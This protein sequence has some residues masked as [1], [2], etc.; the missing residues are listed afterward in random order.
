MDMLIA[1]LGLSLAIGLLVGLERGW[2]ERSEPEGSRTAGIRTFGV[3]GLLGGVLAALSDASGSAAIFIAGFLGFA[4]I[5]GWFKFAEAQHDGSFSVTG[6][7]AAL[8]VFAL[9]GLAVSGDY[10]AAAA[11]GAALAAVLASRDALHGMLRR[12]SWIE[13]RSAIVLAVMT[14]IILP[15][16]PNRT[17]DPWGGFNPWQIWFFTVLTA[18]ISFA[19]YIATRLLGSARG[20]LVSGL[21]GAIVSSTAVTV[22]FARSATASEHRRAYAGAA[23]LAAM[24]SIGRVI[25]IVAIVSPLVLG[26]MVLPALAAAIAFGLAGGLMLFR[27]GAHDTAS[28]PTNPFELTTLLLFAIAFAVVATASAALSSRFG[29]TGLVATSALSGTFDVDVAVLSAL[30]LAAQNIGLETIG[31]AVLAALGANAVGRLALA[32]AAGPRA[33]WVPLLMTNLI[34]AAAGT[35]VW[36]MA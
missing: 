29:D 31:S 16:L 22:A 10:R 25:L 35:T 33:F 28:E 15:L 23:T 20:L 18:S 2:R 12:L 1:R 17:L 13:L 7:I 21:A 34:A 27:A 5:F 24:I 11:G 32:I 36:L 14:V 26:S 8:C 30:R 4:V 19:G 6:T 9:G 3:V